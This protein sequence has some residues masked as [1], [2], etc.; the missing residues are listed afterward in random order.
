MNNESIHIDLD[1]VLQIA[2]TGVK[3][4]SVFMGLG[5]NAAINDNFNKYQLSEITSLVFNLSLMTS[6]RRQ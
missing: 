4:A 6:Q 5:V 3:R 1:Q 2:L